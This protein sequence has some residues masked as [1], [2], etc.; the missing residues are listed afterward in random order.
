V[1]L[2]KNREPIRVMAPVPLPMHATLAGCGWQGEVFTL[3]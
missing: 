1:P 2:Y 3:V